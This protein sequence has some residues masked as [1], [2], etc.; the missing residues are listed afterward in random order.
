[1]LACA[2]IGRLTGRALGRN[3]NPGRQAAARVD[4]ALLGGIAASALWIDR[5]NYLYRIH[6]SNG[7]ETDYI[8]ENS[9]FREGN[10]VSVQ[11]H[12]HANLRRVS[13]AL[14]QSPPKAPEIVLKR[15]IQAMQC[16][17]AKSKY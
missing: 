4:G 11:R 16:R 5:R 12:D 10:C 8:T 9:F 3:S 13:N 2:I 15:K 1:M 17:H 6:Q 14:C 7:L